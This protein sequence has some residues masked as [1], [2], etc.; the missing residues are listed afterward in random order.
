M[1]LQLKGNKPNTI[2]F[3]TKT[4]TTAYCSEGHS[5]DSDI[6]RL[7]KQLE[8]IRK[9][10]D[11]STESVSDKME[12]KLDDIVRELGNKAC[13]ASVSEIVTEN[14]KNIDAV[15]GDLVADLDGL[16]SLYSSLHK[17]Q[18]M[19]DSKTEEN[20]KEINQT[21]SLSEQRLEQDHIVQQ[22]ILKKIDDLEET[23]IQNEKKISNSEENVRKSLMEMRRDQDE[24]TN[25]IKDKE[26]KIEAQKDLMLE[27][28]TLT[29]EKIEDLQNL[30]RNFEADVQHF[31]NNIRIEIRETKDDFEKRM[32][33]HIRIALQDTRARYDDLLVKVRKEFSETK[34]DMVK[35][36]EDHVQLSI[37]DSRSRYDDLVARIT[38]QVKKRDELTM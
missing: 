26:I 18:E 7:S 30:T 33:E 10:N 9:G 17:K 21:I 2:T 28:L 37:L 25:N 35:S 6:K 3:R 32:A 14:K 8:E 29:E 38:A 16:Q 36:I 4:G 27:K 12:E 24:L 23:I 31:S 1:I 5:E 11:T 13:K 22:S 19:L 15:K 20:L 34:R